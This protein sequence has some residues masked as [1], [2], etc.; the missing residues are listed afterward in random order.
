MEGKYPELPELRE[1][2]EGRRSWSPC[3]PEISASLVSEIPEFCQLWEW[4]SLVLLGEVG[5]LRTVGG[6]CSQSFTS[7]QNT[8]TTSVA[9]V[10]ATPLKA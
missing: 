3:P 6:G 5:D 10:S 9:P 8:A 2:G 1:M 7:P 4:C